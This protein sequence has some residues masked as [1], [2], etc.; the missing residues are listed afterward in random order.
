V[1]RETGLAALGAEHDIGVE[2]GDEHIEVALVR[3]G[4]E[5]FDDLP[6]GV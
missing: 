3:R 6:L 4:F 5:R 1:P 2:N